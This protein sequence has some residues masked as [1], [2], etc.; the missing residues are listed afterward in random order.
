MFARLAAA[1][2]LKLARSRLGARAFG[3]VVMVTV[4]DA[5]WAEIARRLRVT[6][7][8]AKLAAARAIG[9]LPAS[10]TGT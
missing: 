4:E 6:V 1:R 7:R 9:R 10:L 2:R 8:A 3:L 5:P